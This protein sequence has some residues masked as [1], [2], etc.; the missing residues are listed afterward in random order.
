MTTS[1]FSKTGLSAKTLNIGFQFDH[2][3]LGG[4]L[5]FDNVIYTITD[6]APARPTELGLDAVENAQ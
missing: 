1:S 2:Y 3:G 6:T 4:S 5:Y